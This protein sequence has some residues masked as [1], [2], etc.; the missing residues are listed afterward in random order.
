MKLETHDGAVFTDETF[1]PGYVWFSLERWPHLP[2]NTQGKVG[3]CVIYRPVWTDTYDDRELITDDMRQAVQ[4]HYEAQKAA[5]EEKER[6]ELDQLNADLDAAER[7]REAM[8]ESAKANLRRYGSSEKA[9]EAEDEQA[10]A[11]LRRYGY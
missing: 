9:W 11:Q 3:Y 7:N 10:W 2:D 8:P 6:R 5:R 4:E 1:S